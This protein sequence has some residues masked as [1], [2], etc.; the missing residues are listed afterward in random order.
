MPLDTG[1]TPFPVVQSGR[2]DLGGQFAPNSAWLAYQ[3]NESG[4]YQVSLRRI[5]GGGRGVQ[6]SADGGTQPRGDGRELYYLDLNRRLMAVPVTFAPDGASVDVGVP[7]PPL[8]TRIGGA[9]IAQKEYL[10][11]PDGQRFLLDTPIGDSAPPIR[12]I[13]NWRPPS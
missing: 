5:R 1:E 3:S 11:A 4:R 2:E 9:N 8:Q 10:A 7:A 6:V 12:A 13:L